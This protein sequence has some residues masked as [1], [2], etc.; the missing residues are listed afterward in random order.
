MTK[1]FR[2]VRG[3]VTIDLDADEVEVLR[4]MAAL[5]LDLVE[6]PPE[7]DEFESIVGIGTS[8]TRPDDP[9]LARLFPDAYSDDAESAGDFRRYTEDGLRRHKRENAQAVAAALPPRGGGRITLDLGDAH[10]WLKALNDVRLVL[11]TRLGVEEETFEAYLRG[12][13][14]VPESEAVAMHVYDWLGGLQET[15]VQA[16][17]GAGSKGRR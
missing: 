4:S 15:L 1:G 10:A 6:P 12:E 8:S 11:G 13:Y 5:V 9:V 16:L 2:P 7:R 14:T 3:G 17:F